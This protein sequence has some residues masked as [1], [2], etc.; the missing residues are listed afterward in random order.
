[1]R[2]KGENK[3]EY[4]FVTLISAVI[5]TVIGSGIFF[6]TEEILNITDGNPLSGFLVL[7]AGG[8][9]TVLCACAFALLTAELGSEGGVVGCAEKTCGRGLALFAAIFSA[10]F[11]LPSMTAALAFVS[12]GYFCAF[13]GVSDSPL[14]R[15]AVANS[16]LVLF[17]AIN[18][19][20]PKSAGR[21]QVVSTAVKL[22]PII[23]VGIV[24]IISLVGERETVT[25]NPVDLGG[26]APALLSSA[27]AYEGWVAVTAIGGEVKNPRR[28]MPLA[29]ITGSASVL[30][31]YVLYYF[32]VI[33]ASQSGGS[34]AAFKNIFGEGGGKIML[35]FVTVSCLG[36]LNGLSMSVTRGHYQLSQMLGRADRGI[37]A[38]VSD[39]TGVPVLSGI[40][41]LLV[42]QGWLCF[43]VL[44]EMWGKIIRIDPSE[45]SISVMYAVYVPIFVMAAVRLKRVE[46]I[47]RLAVLIPAVI[48]AVTVAVAAPIS[49]GVSS[50]VFASIAAAVSGMVALVYCR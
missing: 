4:G 48:S 24:G 28:N 21:F 9:I 14:L 45:A 13:V 11:Y 18:T 32:G 30:V 29:L 49:F 35:A 37:F 23:A 12:G 42:S 27:F 43:F 8:V 38:E 22:L 19:L 5:G 40:M 41:G 2:L 1:M 36:A 34:I 25:Y 15:V 10:D 26:V 20:A 31:M 17:F 44:R 3:K 46:P 7:L 39:R 50:I 33:G 16:L 47:K 6:K